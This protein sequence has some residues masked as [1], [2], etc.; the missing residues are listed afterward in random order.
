MDLRAL[1]WDE[2]Q[3]AFSAPIAESTICC[4]SRNAKAMQ[5][6]P[7]LRQP[8][9][10]ALATRPT[11]PAVPKAVQ[12]CILRGAFVDISSLFTDIFHPTLTPR[13][14]WLAHSPNNDS[15]LNIVESDDAKQVCRK[16]HDIATWLEACTTY[17]IVIIAAAPH[18][19]AELFVYPQFVCLFV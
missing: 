13:T 17:M 2:V 5:L 18:C 16:V 8:K 11:A 12:E 10:H 9:P 7:P 15:Q 4:T 3:S 14:I 6:L 1:V 19:T